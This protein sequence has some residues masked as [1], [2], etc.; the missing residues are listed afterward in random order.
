MKSYIPSVTLSVLLLSPSFVNAN[1]VPDSHEL[2]TFSMRLQSSGIAPPQEE[3]GVYV[4]NSGPGLDTGCTFAS[5]GPLLI[6]LPVPLVV[7][8]NV[9]LTDGRIDPNKLGTMQQKGVISPSARISM[10]VFDIDSNAS[11]PN[12]APEIDVVSFNGKSL[13]VLQGANGRWTDTNLQVDI[14]DIKFGQD[15]VIRVDIDTGNTEDNWC[16]SVDWVS[17]EFDIAIPVVLAHGIAAQSDT[18]DDDTAPGVLSTL[19]DYGIRYARFSAEKNGT[20]ATNA[21]ILNNKIQDFLDEFKSEKVHVIAHSKGGLDTQN[22]KALSPSFEIKSLSTFST[23]H[24]GS[25]AADLS[26]IKMDHYANIYSNVSTDPNN[27]AGKYMQLPNIPF[28][29]PKMPGI[30]DLTTDTASNALQMRTR[31]NIRNTFSIGANAELNQDGVIEKDPDIVGLF[32]WGSRWAGVTA[33]HALRNFSSAAYLD[34]KTQSVTIPG[35]YGPQAHSITTVS[36]Q[37]I[38][39]TPQENDVVVTLASANPSYANSLGNVLANHSTMK[40]GQNV[41]RFLQQIISMR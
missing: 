19:D 17:I 9:L 5:G 39:T 29:G 1:D 35:A 21:N 2:R 4:V 38:Q 18:W 33:W 40:T 30:R 16:M 37:S 25:V 28:A 8:P 32:P 13:G 15:N 20:T 27:Y 34:T 22:L 23:P 11:V 41:E 24:L 12:I 36:Y 3:L 26:V 31:G 14:G 7:N 6:S 10:P